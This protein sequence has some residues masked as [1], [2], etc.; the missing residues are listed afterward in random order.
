V[1]KVRNG[2]F[3]DIFVSHAP[4]KGVHEG[5]DWTHQGIKAFRW[6]VDSFK[7]A[8]H[9][10]GHIHYYHPDDSSISQLGET[11]VINAYRSRVVEIDIDEKERA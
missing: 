4:P 11:T 5:Q 2:R 9:F 7:P 1:N 8:Y 3:L 6:L 10:H